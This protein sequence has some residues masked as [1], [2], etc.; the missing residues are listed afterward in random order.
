MF[1]GE[2]ARKRFASPF[3]GGICFEN[4]IGNDHDAEN[5]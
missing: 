4:C 1:D 5:C 2:E 3:Y